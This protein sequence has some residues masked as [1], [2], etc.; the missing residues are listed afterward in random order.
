MFIRSGDIRDRTLKWSEIDLNLARFWPQL[1]WER[2][3]KFWNLGYKIQEPSDHVAKFRGDRPTE[4]GD[5]A[6]KQ[7]K[8]SAVK[9]KTT[10]NYRAGWPNDEVVGVKMTLIS[11]PSLNHSSLNPAGR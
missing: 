1:F 9:H 4:L 6:L 7:K 2:P 8:T 5:L 10:G 11:P 3:P